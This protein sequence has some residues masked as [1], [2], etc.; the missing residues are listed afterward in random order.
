MRSLVIVVALLVSVL[1][2]PAGPACA[3]TKA[4]WQT[5]AD[6][7]A[8]LST[9]TDRGFT[10]AIV[11]DDG[12]RGHNTYCVTVGAHI[13][14]LRVIAIG[15]SGVVLSNGRVLPNTSASA[16]PATDVAAGQ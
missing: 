4:V 7:I 15:P 12:M 14:T 10:Y 1:A 13:G 16:V 6:S 8:I 3:Q 5:P 11:R 2:T 9:G